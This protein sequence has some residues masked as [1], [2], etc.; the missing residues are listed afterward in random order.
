MS[1]DL[2]AAAEILAAAGIEEPLREA[3]ILFRES[4]T[5]E[6]F[7]RYIHRRATHEPVAYILGRREFWSLEFEVSPAVLIPRPDS[8]TLVE[9]VLQEFRGRP[10]ENI[11]D[12]GTGSGC[13]LIALL[14]EW[15]SSA[16]TAVD[17]SVQS[18]SVATRNAERLGV[19]A[20]INFLNQ[21]FAAPIAGKFDLVISNPPYIRTDVIATLDR[22]VR[23][24]EPR[25]A[26]DGGPSGLE[27]LRPLAKTLKST[28]APGAVAA[29]EIGYDQAEAVSQTLQNQGLRVIRIVK[30]LGGHDRVVVATMPQ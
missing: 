25:L 28:L 1:L 30:D 26:L 20:R 12:L 14:T 27:S 24:F 9:T 8:E 22:D 19:G 4:K 17:I 16:G 13:L 6:D 3:R 2:K 5:P 29:I 10:P 18:L 15:P 21:D 11:L 23:D 7:A